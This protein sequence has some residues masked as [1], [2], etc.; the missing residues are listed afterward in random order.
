[1]KF[2][3]NMNIHPACCTGNVTEY[4]SAGETDGQIRTI[5]A[6]SSNIANTRNVMTFSL[7]V[8]LKKSARINVF[9]HIV[10]HAP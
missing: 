8:W 4:K 3:K 1:M 9:G 6:Q 2:R 5:Y 10:A 7:S